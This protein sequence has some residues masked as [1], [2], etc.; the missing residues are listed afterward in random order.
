VV[1]ASN[2]GLPVSAGGMRTVS[3]VG[4]FRF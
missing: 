2:Y 1:N 3:I 4:R